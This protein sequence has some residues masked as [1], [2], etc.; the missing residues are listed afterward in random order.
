MESLDAATTLCYVVYFF[1]QLPVVLAAHLRIVRSSRRFSSSFQAIQL[2]SSH[3]VTGSNQVGVFAT[4]R[5]ICPMRSSLAGGFPRNK[6][7]GFE[8]GGTG[9]GGRVGGAC[10][11]RRRRCSRSRRK[12]GRHDRS[13]RP[14]WWAPM[15]TLKLYF[16]PI[17]K[18]G[19]KIR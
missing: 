16:D 3:V 5:P 17:S 15:Q 10:N 18:C 9:L 1:S 8:S 6:R 13:Q 4:Q 2:D 12:P 7:Q 19:I 11:L 14:L